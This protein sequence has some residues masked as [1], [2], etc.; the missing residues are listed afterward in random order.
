MIVTILGDDHLIA[1]GRDGGA[2]TVVAVGRAAPT[3][4]VTVLG[5][6]AERV[7]LNL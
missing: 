3:K 5:A 1:N 4:S 2:T 6:H 7:T